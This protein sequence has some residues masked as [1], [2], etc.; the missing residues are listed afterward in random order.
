MRY[1]PHYGRRP[2]RPCHP[3]NDVIT[4]RKHQQ[5]APIG[6]PT[7]EKRRLWC[8]SLAPVGLPFSDKTCGIHDVG[9]ILREVLLLSDRKISPSQPGRCCAVCM[10]TLPDGTRQR[11]ARMWSGGPAGGCIFCMVYAFGKTGDPR[12][13]IDRVAFAKTPV[14]HNWGDLTPDLTSGYKRNP[15]PGARVCPSSILLLAAIFAPIGCCCLLTCCPFCPSTHISQSSKL[16]TGGETFL[17][18]LRAKPRTK[19]A[20][21]RNGRC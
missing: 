7:N 15:R 6:D 3:Y 16:G 18:A 14:C 12:E 20:G 17:A 13:H 1:P 21:S 8:G 10:P 4:P 19:N 9:V 11:R 2:C 5:F